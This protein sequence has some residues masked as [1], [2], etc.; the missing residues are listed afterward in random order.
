[1]FAMSTAD[2]PAGAGIREAEVFGFGAVFLVIG[3]RNFHRRV[4]S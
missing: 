2:A 3:P 1:M 4:L